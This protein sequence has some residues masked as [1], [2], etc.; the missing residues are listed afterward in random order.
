MATRYIGI[1]ASDGI[2]VVNSDVIGAASGGTLSG[3]QN[4]QVVFDDAVYDSTLEGKQRLAAAI[5]LI[6]D[7][8]ATAR[9]WPI[10]SS[11]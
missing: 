3:A 9:E 2:Q 8:I 1:A 7:R 11:S 10:T 5:E 4:V 6:R